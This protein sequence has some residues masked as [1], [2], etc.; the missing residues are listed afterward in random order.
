MCEKIWIIYV[1][2]ESS[3]GW[4]IAVMCHLFIF[5]VFFVT[6]I[7]LSGLSNSIKSERT[8]SKIFP[9]CPRSDL[10]GGLHINSYKPHVDSRPCGDDFSLC[11]PHGNMTLRRR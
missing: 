7:S 4:L 3:S 9:E 6:V 5:Y 11:L 1:E 8:P 10:G 2:L